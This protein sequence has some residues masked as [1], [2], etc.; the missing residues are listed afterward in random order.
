MNTE[1]EV[2][3]SELRILLVHESV[4]LKPGVLQALDAADRR[5]IECLSRASR[6]SRSLAAW[7]D[8][9]FG[10]SGS[11]AALRALAVRFNATAVRLDCELRLHVDNAADRPALWFGFPAEPPERPAE[12]DAADVIVEPVVAD[13]PP[14]RRS[15]TVFVSYADADSAWAVPFIE[16]LKGLARTHDGIQ[17]AFWYDKS[18]LGSGLWRKQIRE[19]VK[20]SAL[21]LMLLTPAF[22][23]SNFVRDR[24]LPHF[25][26]DGFD[27]DNTPCAVIGCEPVD[28]S[29]LQQ[30]GI[31]ASQIIGC[32]NDSGVCRYAELDDADKAAFAS[33]VFAKLCDQ[34]APLD[35]PDADT[36]QAHARQLEA[37][38]ARL[39]HDSVEHLQRNEAMVASWA[40][41]DAENSVTE[42]ARVDL[43]D[44]LTDWALDTVAPQFCALLGQYGTGKTTSL[45]RLARELHARHARGEA[46]PLPI[47]IDL[48]VGSPP[49]GVPTLVDLLEDHIRGRETLRTSGVTAAELLGLVR[50]AGALMLFD[51]LDEKAVRMSRGETRRFV[52]EL[53]KTFGDTPDDALRCTGKL[54]ISCRSHY[55]RDLREQTR[56]FL[57]AEA[58]MARRAVRSGDAMSR[59]FPLFVLLPFGREQVLSYLV[60]TL[61]DTEAAERAMALI[62]KTHDLGQLATRPVLLPHL[63]RQLAHLERCAARG[64]IVNAAAVYDAVVKE[65]LGRDEEKHQIDADD[66]RRLMEEL[67][68]KLHDEERQDLPVQLLDEW[69][70]QRFRDSDALRQYS[71]ASA[72]RFQ[73][74]LR[75]A[76]FIV[77]AEFTAGSDLFRFAHTSLAEYFL[78]CHLVRALRLRQ[79]QAWDIALPSRETLDF[80]V[81]LIVRL[82]PYEQRAIG[83]TW[84]SLLEAGGRGAALAFR[85]WLSARAQGAPEPDPARVLLD[86]CD[87]SEVELTGTAA[88]PLR[89]RNASLREAWLMRTRWRRVELDDADF[90]GAYL[91]DAE[92]DECRLDGALFD[93]AD[94]G[95]MQV[96]FGSALGG[97]TQ[98]AIGSDGSRFAL[99]AA[100][101]AAEPTAAQRE[102]RIVARDYTSADVGYCARSPGGEFVVSARHDGCIR[103][104]ETATGSCRHEIAD[105]NRRGNVAFSPDGRRLLVPQSC[106]RLVIWDLDRDGLTTIDVRGSEIICCAFSPDGKHA[107]AGTA[108]AEVSLWNLATGVRSTL[109]ARQP[110]RARELVD[111]AFSPDGSLVA[112]AFHRHASVRAMASGESL[113]DLRAA[114]A[115]FGIVFSADGASVATAGSDGMVRFWSVSDGRLLRSLPLGR[116]SRIVL[117]SDATRAAVKSDDDC[118]QIWD[119]ADRSLGFVYYGATI[120]RAVR[121]VDTQRLL[122][123]IRYGYLELYDCPSGR[124]LRRFDVPAT[125]QPTIGVALRGDALTVASEQLPLRR[126]SLDGIA[127]PSAV[128]VSPLRIMALSPDLTTAMGYNDRS[129]TLSQLDARSG[130]Y[131]RTMART[132]TPVF[133]PDGQTFTVV[134]THPDASARAERAPRTAAFVLELVGRTSGR[135]LRRLRPD[136]PDAEVCV[137]LTDDARALVCVHSSAFAWNLAANTGCLLPIEYVLQISCAALSPNRQQV[138]IGSK[139]G[140][141]YLCEIDDGR[142]VRRFIG[143]KGAVD[144]CGFSG[145][146]RHIVSA[147]QDGTRRLWTVATGEGYV[148]DDG[149]R[150]PAHSLSIDG[151]RFA[152]ATADMTVRIWNFAD[153]RCVRRLQLLPNGEFALFE[154]GR[155]A[156]L[157]ASPQAWRHCLTR[158]TGADGRVR[159]MPAEALTGKWPCGE[160][161]DAAR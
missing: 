161:G 160:P 4:E 35:L 116:V 111:I 83:A 158:V 73:G 19:A 119:L 120:V 36:A 94:C 60:A 13:T 51:G 27:S 124:C 141:L 71:T 61:G 53:W 34:L 54:V 40:D 139:Y 155:L 10:E 118:L 128:D 33:L 107:I 14:R 90:S 110:P 88:R 47:Y 72:E 37:A 49:S 44:A 114:D 99:H 76:T 97:G 31:D 42:P 81:Q 77:R 153:G 2:H 11:I 89:L 63:V 100:A 82:Q 159:L 30:R 148:L 126:W 92:F 156:P 45:R 96:R 127:A 79:P 146:G 26:Y 129:W 138:L 157:L 22:L 145:D 62:E 144:A 134:V 55:F 147:A 6:E 41:L 84:G 20:G 91:C 28:R 102:I 137:T 29:V 57:A 21:G 150:E 32:R 1:V 132:S 121:F 7:S 115:R 106:G 58:S 15:A 125:A 70:V 86:G 109:L 131:M 75:T 149:P 113:L 80:V 122:L 39:A 154:P 98:R 85:C 64:E 112:I 133:S 117:S 16:A 142:Y 38:L 46:V 69:L 17:V 43:L 9:A 24:E 101:I 65:W 130:A 68:A 87:L 67:A 105:W 66:K 56:I 152:T 151:D 108:T 104:I 5:S 52:N 8:C 95:G 12:A 23:R 93:A 59:E 140:A 50:K 48:R 74:D 78:A 25:D 123:G 143:H 18:N 136:L 103:I 3:G 135:R